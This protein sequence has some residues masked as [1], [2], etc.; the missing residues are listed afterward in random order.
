MPGRQILEVV[1]QAL[2]RELLENLP[3][4]GSAE[5]LDPPDEFVFAHGVL[6]P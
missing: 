4:V 5:P 3:V 1:R 6:L 2:I